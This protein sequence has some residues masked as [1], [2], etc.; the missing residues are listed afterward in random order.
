MLTV[1]ELKFVDGSVPA[2]RTDIF[3]YFPQ[4]GLLVSTVSKK[5]GKTNGRGKP[6]KLL[7]RTWRNVGQRR[8]R[9]K[10]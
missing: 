9:D 5:K 6:G 10:V 3:L 8:R 4:P 7:R 1:N 2:T